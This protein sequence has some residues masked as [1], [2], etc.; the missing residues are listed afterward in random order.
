[1]GVACDVNSFVTSLYINQFQI[2]CGS[3][4]P[5]IGQVSIAYSLGILSLWIP[6][7]CHRVSVLPEHATNREHAPKWHS[8]N[9]FGVAKYDNIVGGCK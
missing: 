8:S 2:S 5:Q 3:I 7:V 1:M 9:Y 4:P 6:A